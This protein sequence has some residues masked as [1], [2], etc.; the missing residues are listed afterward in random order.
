[1]K[2]I[3]LFFLVLLLAPVLYSC[4]GNRNEDDSDVI[5]E[6]I[7]IDDFLIPNEK[8]K[9]TIGEI[10]LEFLS[11]CSDYHR[12][13]IS[14]QIECPASW[15][16][17]RNSNPSSIKITEI[18]TNRFYLTIN[19][20]TDAGTYVSWNNIFVKLLL[21]KIKTILDTGTYSLCVTPDDISPQSQLSSY[22]DSIVETVIYFRGV[23]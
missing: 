8:V 21:Q 15:N 1:M 17:L 18:D 19:E 22:Y 3:S 7:F 16:V 11:N 23:L 6:D 14:F 12:D 4:N 20:R 9:E 2:H 5:L 10:L 13:T